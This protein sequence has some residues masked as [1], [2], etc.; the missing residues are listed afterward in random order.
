MPGSRGGKQ[1]RP[2]LFFADL[3][4]L[5]SESLD[6]QL[7]LHLAG[8]TS[9]GG[10]QV[11][12]GVNRPCSGSHGHPAWHDRDAKASGTAE[13]TMLELRLHTRRCMV[14]QRL[15][16]AAPA[17]SQQWPAREPQ[18]AARRPQHCSSCTL[19]CAASM[20]SLLAGGGGAAA[21]W[22]LMCIATPTAAVPIRPMPLQEALPPPPP[23]AA[24]TLAAAIAA[25]CSCPPAAPHPP[26]AAAKPPPARCK[27]RDH[28]AGDSLNRLNRRC[29]LGAPA[30]ASGSRW[31]ATARCGR[32]GGRRRM[33]GSTAGPSAAR[34]ATA[35]QGH[36]PP[37]KAAHLWMICF[38]RR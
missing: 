1:P 33:K 9:V 25:A 6:L 27:G 18:R 11:P 5:A 37:H 22:V 31:P 14:P 35:A 13:D 10:T 16:S 4:Y 15:Q 7:R 12:F 38:L 21:T 36:K 8:G 20:L 2:S 28:A 17:S 24:A 34:A 26:I 29:Q 19:R 23:P 30:H 3:G 32:S